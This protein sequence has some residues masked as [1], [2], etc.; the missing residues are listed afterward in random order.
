VGNHSWDHSHLA[1]LTPQEIRTQLADTQA[2]LVAAGAP[3]PTLLRPPFGSTGPAV[4]AEAEALRLREVRWSVDTNDWRG[5]APED[6][7]A[8]VLDKLAP[9]AV[10]LLHDHSRESG[11]TVR[12]LPG[13]I[14]AAGAAS[15]AVMR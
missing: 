4:R 7:E 13:I 5:R 10:I 11:N 6:I 2:A 9:G 14:G 15:A 8:A 3:P 12:A 1:D